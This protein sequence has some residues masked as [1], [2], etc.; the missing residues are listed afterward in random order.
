MLSPRLGSVKIGAA[1]ADPELI[2]LPRSFAALAPQASI[3]IPHR[4]ELVCAEA[5]DVDRELAAARMW[6]DCAD[7]PAAIARV[8]RA[9][10]D[11]PARWQRLMQPL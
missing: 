10:D 5:G 4:F 8:I 3:E 2:E 1:K 7:G 6:T 11:R 9:E